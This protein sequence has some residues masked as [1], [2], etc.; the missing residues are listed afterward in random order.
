V[1][2]PGQKFYDGSTTLAPVFI[3]LLVVAL[4]MGIVATSMPLL[5]G[6]A[7]AKGQVPLALVGIAVVVIAVVLPLGMF[8]GLRVIVTEADV[9]LFWGLFG[10]IKMQFRIQDVESF[11]IVTFRPLWDFG[12][13]GWRMGKDGSRCY[14]MQGNRGI[15]LRIGGRSYIIGVDDP[16]NLAQAIE[17]STTRKADHPG[18]W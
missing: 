11:R 4:A 1:R 12:G 7:Q 10:W 8:L 5:N 17:L 6:D 3:A 14:N 2:I 9:L 15:E 13:W 16:E 18:D